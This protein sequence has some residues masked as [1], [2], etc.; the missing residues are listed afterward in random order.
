MDICPEGAIIQGEDKSSI[1]P[2]K[3]TDCGICVN[4]FFCPAQA[5][6]KE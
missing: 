1:D 3:C 2:E 6:I 5:I 4:E